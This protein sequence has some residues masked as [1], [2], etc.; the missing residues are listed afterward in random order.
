MINSNLRR[1]KNISKEMELG[2]KNYF[3]RNAS[4]FFKKWEFKE[5]D[6]GIIFIKEN[7]EYVLIGQVTD[8]KFYL[9]NT[10]DDSRWFVDG[11]Y[12][13]KEFERKKN[14]S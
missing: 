11:D 7:E 1:V 8:S 6:L 13:M 2:Y 12:L 5:D 14:I 10:T 4:K 3:I 9:K